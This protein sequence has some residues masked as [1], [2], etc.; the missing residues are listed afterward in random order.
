MPLLRALTRSSPIVLSGVPWCVCR[1]TW[2]G[3]FTMSFGKL[4]LFTKYVAR[5]IAW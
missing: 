1:C 3:R 4:T 5:A 2:P